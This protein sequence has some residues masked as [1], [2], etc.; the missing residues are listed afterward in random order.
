MIAQK[1]PYIGSAYEKLQIISQDKE[2]RMEY[3]A[4]EK[5]IRDY[6]EMML[7]AIERTREETKEETRREEAFLTAQRLIALGLPIDIVAQ[8]SGLTLEQV[9]ALKK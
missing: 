6:N 1:D 9:Q 4:R 3:E 7:T 5:A 8:G 2:K